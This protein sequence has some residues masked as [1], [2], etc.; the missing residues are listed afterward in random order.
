M[1]KRI[2]FFIIAFSFLNSL[3][4]QDSIYYRAKI[5][6][7]KISEFRKADAKSSQSTHP[8]LFIGSSSFTRWTSLNSCFPEYDILNRGFGGSITSD[9]IY[10][11]E[12]II[13]RYKPSQIF[14]YEGDKDL[15]NNMTIDEFMIDIKTLVRIIEIRL[16]G[17]PVAILSI[18]SSPKRDRFRL[19]YETANA[20]LKEFTQT[21]SN[22]TFIDVA[23]VLIDEQGKYSKD[24]FAPDSLHIN[25]SAYSLWADHIR[26]HLITKNVQTK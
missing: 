5:W 15:S 12:D 16:P 13:F 26:P 6:D 23:S 19:K 22:L 21:K 8:I 10:Y 4:A 25:E 14:I 7:S 2:C 1:I 20:R 9:L 11:A 18:K 3:Y 24:M 17:V